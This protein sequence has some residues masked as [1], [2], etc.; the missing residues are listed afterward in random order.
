VIE[1]NNTFYDYLDLLEKDFSNF[2]YVMFSWKSWSWKSTYI[3]KLKS[4]NKTLK[5]FVVIDEI[6][7]FYDFI[8]NI[9]YFSSSKKSFLIASHIPSFLYY[10][11]TLFWKIKNYSTDK[12]SKKICKYLDEK[13]YKYSKNSIDIYISKFKANYTDLDIILENYK[14]NN[15]DSALW[16]FLKYNKLVLDTKKSL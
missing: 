5:D 15:F 10:I 9:K 2:K 3:R 16:Y 13:W 12:C 6:Y 11:L 7:D 1:K 14:W 8:K 4:T